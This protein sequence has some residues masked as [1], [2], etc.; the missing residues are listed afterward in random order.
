MSFYPSLRC[1]CQALPESSELCYDRNCLAM[2]RLQNVNVNISG[3][4]ILAGIDLCLPEGVRAAI[5]GPS[6][7]GKSTLLKLLCFMVKPSSGSV[8][9]DGQ[10]ASALSIPALRRKIPLT[11]QE[12]VLWGE[13]VAENFT[14]PFTFNS[15]IGERGP[16]DEEIAAYLE[17]VELDPEFL[18][19]RVDTLSGGE[20]QRV[21]IARALCLKPRALLLD[22]PTS[23]L[24]LVTAE[25]IFNNITAS[26]PGL[27]LIMATHS[28]ELIQR[29]RMQVLIKDGRIQ[30]V[31][32][33]LDISKLKKFLDKGK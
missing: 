15:A 29:T 32:E 10:R 3:K 8:E 21:A 1:S 11:Y 18:H 16:S 6:G 14:L 27:A 20:K 24:D 5:V 13:T 28:P 17:C 9:F 22:E 19:K 26:L 12:P 7:S 23:A 31:E 25:N 33:S 4:T 30:S 2:F